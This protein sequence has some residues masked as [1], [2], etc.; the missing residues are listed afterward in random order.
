MKNKLEQVISEEQI[1]VDDNHKFRLTPD[2]FS[3]TQQQLENLQTM[4][5]AIHECLE[6]IGHIAAIGRDERLARLLDLSAVNKAL[7]SGV[8]STFRA[9]ATQSPGAIPLSLKVD[10][11]MTN[12]GRFKIGEIDAYNERSL[13]Y[14]ELTAKMRSVVNPEGT[15]LPGVA[16]LL[17]QEIRK[18]TDSGNPELLL[19]Y[20]DKERFYLPEFKIL[21]RSL[22]RLGTRLRIGSEMEFWVSEESLRLRGETIR[23]DLIVYYP[24]LYRNQTL[25]NWLSKATKSGTVRFL[26]PPKPFLGNKTVLALLRNDLNSTQLESTLRTF[27]SESALAT[28]RAFIPPT[29]IMK[30]RSAI[31]SEGRFILK[32]AVSSGAKGIFFPEDTEYEEALKAAL[33]ADSTHILQEEV[34]GICMPVRYFDGDSIASVDSFLRVNAYFVGRTLADMAITATPEKL[35]HGGTKSI[36]MGVVVN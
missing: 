20:A 23:P 1:W 19:I 14:C 11:I 21:A 9:F 12:D 10:L 34:E 4:G 24:F 15:A 13:G 32:R 6:G 25:E 2:C 7:W 17:D 8:P 18:L 5:R 33:K 27:I 35:V 22:A 36:F 3:I 28:V 26:I 29:F 16:N 31:P 30:K